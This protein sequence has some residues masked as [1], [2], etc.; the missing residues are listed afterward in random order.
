ML[1]DYDDVACGWVLRCVALLEDGERERERK[2][3]ARKET[4]NT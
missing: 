2:E 4:D 1:D 3:S